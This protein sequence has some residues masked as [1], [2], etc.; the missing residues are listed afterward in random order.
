M[1]G[2]SHCKM[3]WSRPTQRKPLQE[4]SDWR[5]FQQ[6]SSSLNG[7]GREAST[8]RAV[9]YGCCPHDRDQPLHKAWS[10]KGGVG[11]SD[12]PLGTPDALIPSNAAAGP[13]RLCGGV[14]D[15]EVPLG[16]DL[17]HGFLNNRRGY[18]KTAT[19][20]ASLRPLRGL[21]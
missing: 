18:D 4:N 14:P 17:E 1:W 21:Q 9:G 3:N 13:R 11:T 12:L 10:D 6:A 2:P 7:R 8:I 5:L 15:S 16:K 20:L 19:Q